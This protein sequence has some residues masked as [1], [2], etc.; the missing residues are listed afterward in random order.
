MYEFAAY[1]NGADAI[2]VGVGSLTVSPPRFPRRDSK[3]T[4]NK[5]QKLKSVSLFIYFYL[6]NSVASERICIYMHSI[7]S[8]FVTGPK[9]FLFLG[10]NKHF[11][12]HKS[13]RLEQ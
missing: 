12:F 9:H 10:V 11:S 5:V 1:L 7:E 13:D 3:T 2:E 4:V 8:R 6:L